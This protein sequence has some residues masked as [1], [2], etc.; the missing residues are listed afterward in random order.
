ML[1]HEECNK[2]CYSD[3]GELRKNLQFASVTPRTA[4]SLYEMFTSCGLPGDRR[5]RNTRIGRGLSPVRRE[6]LVD[7]I[8]QMIGR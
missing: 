5:I 4:S 2:S 1:F 8:R 7:F 3:E 6:I